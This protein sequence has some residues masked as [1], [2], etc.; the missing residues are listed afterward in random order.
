MK[1]V[2]RKCRMSIWRVWRLLTGVVNVD[3]LLAEHEQD[4]RS[5]Q[6]ESARDPFPVF[7]DAPDE[8]LPPRI[9][10]M[11]QDL[12]IHKIFAARPGDFEDVRI[13]LIKNPDIDKSYI[14]KWLREFDES[15][16]TKEFLKNFEEIL[17]V[18]S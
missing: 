1:K 9:K 18:A 2:R 14:R 13:I 5:F 6:H 4:F 12:I 16:D 7:L 3:T 17:D 10:G 15:S 11:T 8:T